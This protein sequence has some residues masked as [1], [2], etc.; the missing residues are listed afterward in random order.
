MPG[1]G[2]TVAA[3]TYRIEIQCTDGAFTGSNNLWVVVEA[4]NPVTAGVTALADWVVNEGVAA[5]TYSI[6]AGAFVDGDSDKGG[7]YTLTTSLLPTWVSFA[8]TTGLFSLIAA[9]ADTGLV[10]QKTTITITA[11][12]KESTPSTATVTFDLLLNRDP[13][14]TPASTPVAVTVGTPGTLAAAFFTKSDDWDVLTYS[15]VETALTTLPTWIAFDETTQTLTYNATTGAATVTVDVIATD[16]QGGSVTCQVVFTVTANLPPVLTMPADNIFNHLLAVTADPAT[17]T[18]SST[19]GGDGPLALPTFTFA[20]VQAWQ[21]ATDNGDGTFAITCPG[22][23]VDGDY[24]ITV[25]AFDG[26]DSSVDTFLT[27]YNQGPLVANPIGTI[28]VIQDHMTVFNI[29]ANLFSDADGDALTIT[30]D[31][32]G[33]TPTCTGPACVLTYNAG[34]GTITIYAD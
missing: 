12:G 3:G 14:C 24:T 5:G 30:M 7:E 25:T 20:G 6:G 33:V 26:V 31:A 18:G 9:A 34:A 10:N 2:T 16:T 32:T 4:N 27:T 1:P 19:N 17:L 22:P 11:T 23:I 13:T 21:T 15:A 29:P 28:N 8:P